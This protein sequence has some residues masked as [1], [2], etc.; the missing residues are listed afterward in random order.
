MKERKARQE[1][2][3]RK[4]KTFH[5]EVFLRLLHMGSPLLCN[6]LINLTT[7]KSKPLIQYTYLH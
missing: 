5:F 4:Q 2:E 6:E 7:I 1:E 3:V